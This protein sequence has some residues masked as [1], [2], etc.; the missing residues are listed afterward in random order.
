VY[1]KK[2][3]PDDIIVVAVVTDLKIPVPVRSVTKFIDQVFISPDKSDTYLGGNS[4][5]TVLKVLS[6][7]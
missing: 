6:L 5:V 4:N 1:W 3:Y 7:S 2:D